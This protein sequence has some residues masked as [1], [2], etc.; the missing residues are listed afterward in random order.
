M[1]ITLVDMV[2]PHDVAKALGVST[3]WVRVLAR[4]GKLPCVETPLGRL[5]DAEAVE[6]MARERREQRAQ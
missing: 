6:E 2:A 4:E 3:Q 5:F 1:T